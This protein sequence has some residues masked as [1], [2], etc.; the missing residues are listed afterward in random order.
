MSE[1]HSAVSLQPLGDTLVV[2]FPN[3]STYS[4]AYD[5]MGQVLATMSSISQLLDNPMLTSEFAIMNPDALERFVRGYMDLLI[6]FDSP[7]PEPD[8]E[9]SN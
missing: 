7:L 2:T 8:E 1:A 6:D 9:E 5:D 4:R 3:G